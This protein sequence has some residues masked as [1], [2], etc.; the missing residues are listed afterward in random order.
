VTDSLLPKSLPQ[1]PTLLNGCWF[2]GLHNLITRIPAGHAQL[3][4][5][6][7]LTSSTGSLRRDRVLLR[8]DRTAIVLR[9]KGDSVRGRLHRPPSSSCGWR[10]VTIASM[11]DLRT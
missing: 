2:P 9:V 5:T 7:P 3:R 4:P 8:R 1:S 6:R 11:L 10:F